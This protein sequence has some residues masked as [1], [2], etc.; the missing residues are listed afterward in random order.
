[1]Y[2]YSGSI[3]FSFLLKPFLFRRTARKQP[4]YLLASLMEK[5]AK[6]WTR[7]CSL[8]VVQ[9][10]SRL[11]ASLVFPYTPYAIFYICIISFFLERKKRN[12][13]VNAS[14]ASRNRF[15]EI[16]SPLL[17]LRIKNFLITVRLFSLSFSLSFPAREF[18][19]CAALVH[20]CALT[21]L[22]VKIVHRP[23]FNASLKI[24]SGSPATNRF[25]AP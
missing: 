21:E 12:K 16:F 15:V 8:C 13:F 24:I 20:G 14:R 3:Y 1:M 5:W 2:V 10:Q 11:V 6:A 25:I 9:R 22:Q 17:L 19:L 23:R 4:G 7:N 18:H